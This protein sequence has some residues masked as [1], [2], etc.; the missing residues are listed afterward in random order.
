MNPNTL[1]WKEGFKDWIPA[2]Y[3]PELKTLFEEKEE[4]EEESELKDR[5]KLKTTSADDSS[6]AIEGSNFPFLTYWLII[7]LILLSAYLFNQM[8]RF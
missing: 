1:V 6:L 3:V 2:C 7:L 4:E 5:L 8:Q